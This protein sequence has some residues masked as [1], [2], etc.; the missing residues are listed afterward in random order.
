LFILLPIFAGSVEAAMSETGSSD[1][2]AQLDQVLNLQPEMSAQTGACSTSQCRKP[3]AQTKWPSDI[4]KVAGFDSEGFP[5][6]NDGMK[7]W[8]LICGLIARQRVGINVHFEDLDEPA[9][10]GLFDIMKQYLQFP[11]GTS[12]AELNRVRGAAC[13]SIAKLHRSFKSNLVRNYVNEGKEPFELHK[14]LDRQDW[15]MFMETATSEQFKEKSEHFK[16]FRA[17]ITDNHHLG[18]EGYAG[19]E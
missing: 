9:R 2:N 17:R 18:P 19:K 5:T 4:I 12:E 6:N 13:K 7:C 16:N 8:R 10:Q 15:E 1:S 3:R 11:E 14:H